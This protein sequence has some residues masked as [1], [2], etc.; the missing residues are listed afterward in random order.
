MGESDVAKRGVIAF[1]AIS[2]GG[3]GRLEFDASSGRDAAADAAAD[4][5]PNLPAGAF[6]Y[7]RF[8][9]GSGTTAVDATGHGHDLTLFNGVT[10]TAG[11]TGSAVQVNGVDQYLA[12]PALDLTGTQAVTVS[13][14]VNR[15]YS[16]GPRHTLVEL[17]P[18]FNSTTDGFGLFPDDTS[19]SFCTNGQIAVAVNGDVGSTANCFVQ[20]SSGVWHHL[21]AIYNKANAAAL[22]TQ[23]YIDG[24]L[25]AP[26][27]APA[28]SDNTNRFGLQPLFVFSRD[29]TAEF[30][31]GELDELLIYDR[32]LMPAEIAEL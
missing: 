18:N 13:L 14:W 3:C 12:S 20:P 27:G 25:L 28:L 4:V 15:N 2:T 31:A 16:N 30:N 9:D 8:D 10:W 7:W 29:G 17:S 22:E 6:A 5:A 1:V 26:A 24:A 21:V 32:E 23:L 19:S 11:V